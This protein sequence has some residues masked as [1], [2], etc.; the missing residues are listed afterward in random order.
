MM[1]LC[2]NYGFPITRLQAQTYKN[3]WLK[4]Y[5][6]MNNYL[7]YPMEEERSY[8]TPM[9]MVRASCNYTEWCNG[10][11]LQSPGAEGMKLAMFDI[12]Q[13]CLLPGGA[14]EGCFPIAQIHDEL[15]LEIPEGDTMEERVSVVASIMKRKL[16]EV[17][18]SMN[19]RA[20]KV[21]SI[22]M[23]EWSKDAKPIKD[24]NGSLLVWEPQMS[25]TLTP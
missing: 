21:K 6:E 25:T 4:E 5:P 24:E 16:Q 7:A 13:C 18:P 3:V 11:A 9:G 19:F 10:K 15:L 22:L 8:T 20:I 17:L 2:H 14:L 23:R 12:A 1:Q